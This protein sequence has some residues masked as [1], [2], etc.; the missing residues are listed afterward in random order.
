MTFEAALVKAMVLL[1]Q[2]MGKDE[3]NVKFSATLSGEL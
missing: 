1:G 3:F 2:G